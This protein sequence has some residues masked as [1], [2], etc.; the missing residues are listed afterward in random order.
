MTPELRHAVFDLPLCVGSPLTSSDFLPEGQ[1]R[2]LV[3]ALQELFAKLN[4]SDERALS[5]R[6]LTD[7]F[8]WTGADVAVQQDVQELSRVLFNVI[9][10]ALARTQYADVI[11]KLYRGTLAYQ[12]ICMNCAT[13]YERE[14]VFCDVMVQVKGCKSLLDG[15]R[16]LT[17]YEDLTGDNKY[18]CELCQMKTD[19]K[20]GMQLKQLPPIL[21]FSLARFEFDWARE[22]R[23]KITSK[24]HYPLELDLHEF[25]PGSPKYELFAVI[26][27][28]GSAFGGHYHAYIRDVLGT[29]TWVIDP[30]DKADEASATSTL[31]SSP[32]ADSTPTWGKAADSKDEGGP[33]KEESEDVDGFKV[34][35]KKNRKR[36]RKVQDSKQLKQPPTPASKESEVF[37]E[38]CANSALHT[39]W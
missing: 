36:L 39:Y 32:P 1:Q 35:G 25:V 34:A 26:I 2:T 29:G 4:L 23:K 17:T 8:N 28:G 19:A 5:T 7:S 13:M 11:S 15:L 10:E 37:P 18:F 38:D 27:H 6:A 16:H 30:E 33:A 12:T 24:Y 3:Y 9:E 22:Q 14:E 21:T 20:R 31:T